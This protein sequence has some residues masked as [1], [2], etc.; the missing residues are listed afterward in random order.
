[1]STGPDSETVHPL[2]RFGARLHQVLDGL[3][4]VPAWSMTTAEQ[5]G[6]LA[7][8]ARAEARLTVLR[9]RVLVAADSSD[10]AADSAATSTTAWVAE[11]TH[12]DRSAAH[13]DL[14]LARSLDETFAVTRDALSNGLVDAAQAHVIVRS[15]EGLPASVAQP[16][17]DRA[18]KHLVTL[19][20]SHGAGDLKQLGR[21]IF[22]VI[23]SEAADLQEGRRLEAEERAAEPTTYLS[24]F[25]NGDGTHSGR[26]K[27]P[28]LHAAMLTK[29]LHALDSPRRVR[30]SRDSQEGVRPPGPERMGQAFCELLE[31][32][33]ARRLPGAGGASATVV[34]M[35]DCDKLLS[36]LGAA[37]LDT[38]EALSAGLARRLACQAGVVPAVYRRL[39]DGPS[40]VLDLG[41]RRRL[42]DPAQRLALTV[43]D[44]GCT[45]EGCDGPGAWCHAHH[46]VPWSAGGATSVA[47]GRLLCAF[48]HGKAH[49]PSYEVARLPSGRV[50]FH[51]RT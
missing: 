3:V 30:P 28:D 29:A 48:H 2:A 9:L 18:E 36:G 26:F 41:R 44:R 6:L 35:L 47:N 17:R 46:E 51:R 45:A 22:E 43:R 42:H 20:G 14:R 50:R 37:H 16:D 38:G 5:R 19:A 10:V 12:Q 21:R 1:M 8:L 27:V 39:V 49:S 15:V 33:P 13:A 11:R 40:E 25:D 34:V 32:L 23:D 7:D 31:R 24:I 4:E